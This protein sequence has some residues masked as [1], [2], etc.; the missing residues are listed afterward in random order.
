MTNIEYF[1]NF[2][3]GYELQ[4]AGEFIF[5]SANKMFGLRALYDYFTINL[6]L[7]NGAV[8]IE[9]L[10]KILWC[11]YN[12]SD[13]DEL[14][15][16]ENEQL[17]KHNHIELQRQIVDQNIM[18]KLEKCENSLIEVFANYYNKYRYSEYRLEPEKPKIN[19]LLIDYLNIY[20]DEHYEEDKPITKLQKDKFKKLYINIIGELAKKYH[21]KIKDKAYELGLYTYEINSTSNAYIVYNSIGT[22]YDEFVMNTRSIKELILYLIKSEDRGSLKKL[23]AEI[24]PLD[25]D[26]S[27]IKYYLYDLISYR[28]ILELKDV[29]YE[30]YNDFN[31]DELLTRKGIIDLIGNPDCLIEELDE[32]EKE[33]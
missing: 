13:L 2:N 33:E 9:R 6:I 22:L 20:S 5:E 32:C 4:N 30:S 12:I 11:M 31:K 19:S 15:K 26:P 8:G 1:K 25:I 23:S 7:Y 28:Q 24:S 29:V 16:E 14:D 18:S 17:T 10:Q 21:V 3:M 27:S